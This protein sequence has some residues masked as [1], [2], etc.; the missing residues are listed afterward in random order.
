MFNTGGPALSTPGQLPLVENK[1]L[2]LDDRNALS[3]VE[4]KP[5]LLD[6]NKPLPL[7]ERNVLLAKRNALS[8]VEN[9]PLLLDD[10][11]PLPLE[12][13]NALSLVANKPLPLEDK[14]VL[15]LVE[16]GVVSPSRGGSWVGCSIWWRR[17]C[18]RWRMGWGVLAPGGAPSPRRSL[19]VGRSETRRTERW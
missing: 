3:L 12:D 7:E 15:S 10:S 19:M 16:R 9:K 1:P 2:L 14:N 17:M 11:K 4:N 18:L 8:L 6:D 13:K 5:L